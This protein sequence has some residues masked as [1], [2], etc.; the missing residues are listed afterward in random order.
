MYRCIYVY[1]YICT[2]VH[3]YICTYVYMYICIYVYMYICTYVYT[4]IYILYIDICICLITYYD[5]HIYTLDMIWYDMIWYDVHIYI[6]I[7]SLIFISSIEFIQCW[8]ENLGETVREYLCSWVQVKPRSI[9]WLRVWFFDP[10]PKQLVVGDWP[11]VFHKRLFSNSSFSELNLSFWAAL[12][13]GNGLAT[14]SGRQ[15]TSSAS[16]AVRLFWE[17]PG[18]SGTTDPKKWLEIIESVPQYT[19]LSRLGEHLSLRSQQRCPS[20]S[21]PI[22]PGAADVRLRRYLGTRAGLQQLRFQA[23]PWPRGAQ[24]EALCWEME[25][26]IA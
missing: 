5:I 12:K 8:L 10:T 26:S 13:T 2:Y 11:N 22:S 20:A 1:M 14:R 6:Y 15:I 4:F 9:S 18:Q 24:L 21:H 7:N 16:A 25:S 17:Q 23:I 19:R 3:M